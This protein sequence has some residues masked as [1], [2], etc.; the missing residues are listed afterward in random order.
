M[1]IKYR[2]TQQLLNYPEDCV[3]FQMDGTF[4][5]IMYRW[6]TSNPLLNS[7][8]VQL[9]VYKEPYTTEY[10]KIKN[11]LDKQGFFC[12]IED[13]SEFGLGWITKIEEIKE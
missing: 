1:E 12:Q 9:D 4:T 6:F 2:F 11:A 3:Y 5:T 13:E 10:N 8:G 7:V